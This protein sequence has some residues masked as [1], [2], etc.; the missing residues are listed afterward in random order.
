[1]KGAVV[2]AG[3]RGAGA[4]EVA[5]LARYLDRVFEVGGVD[6]VVPLDDLL[7]F[8]AFGLTEGCSAV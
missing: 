5:V 6:H 7:A 3:L 1:M 4:W 8:A 2:L